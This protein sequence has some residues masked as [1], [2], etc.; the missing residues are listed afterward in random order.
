[1]KSVRLNRRQVDKLSDIFA[2]T[3]LICL[4]TIVIPAVLDRIN[5]FL[6]LLGSISTA[7]FLFTSLQFRR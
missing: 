7:F 3:G 5:L 6:V 1:M 4:A 2:D